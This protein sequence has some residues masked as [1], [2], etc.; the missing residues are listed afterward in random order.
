M[1]ERWSRFKIGAGGFDAPS[2]NREAV[3]F[4]LKFVYLCGM[5]PNQA[6]IYREIERLLEWS[7]PVVERLPRSLPY[8]E[9]GGLLIRDLKEALDFVVL[10]FQADGPLERVECINAVVMR[11]TSVKTSY[12]LLNRVR[13]DAI[14]HGQYAQALDMLNVIADQAGKWLRKNKFVLAEQRK[15]ETPR[16]GDDPIQ[17]SLFSEEDLGGGRQS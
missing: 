16:K 4:F 13:R 9:L 3:R 10:A 5:K 11:M 6:S 7:I 15:A 8:K 12:R 1:S 14:S 2:N 17:L